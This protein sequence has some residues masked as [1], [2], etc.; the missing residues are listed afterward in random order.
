MLDQ[1]CDIG[2]AIRVARDDSH[3]LIL[4]EERNKEPQNPQNQGV[5]W[6][7]TRFNVI[8]SMELI[9]LH[10]ISDPWRVDFYVF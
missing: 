9:Y 7:I 1:L 2:G 4:N 6:V 5:V 3:F 8:A 10:V